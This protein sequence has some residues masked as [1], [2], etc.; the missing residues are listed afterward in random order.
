MQSVDGERSWWVQWGPRSF[1]GGGG[2]GHPSTLK[3]HLGVMQIGQH[4]LI[5]HMVKSPGLLLAHLLEYKH[6][7]K[8]C[9][10]PPQTE[11]GALPL[12]EM[13]AQGAPGHGFPEERLWICK[14]Q[15]VL[16]V[17]FQQAW[18]PVSRPWYSSGR[19]AVTVCGSI[20]LGIFC[21]CK[22]KLRQGAISRL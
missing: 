12:P 3:F 2:K 19:V 16:S 5:W 13:A 7:S 21:K 1:I 18:T 17:C 15:I 14:H 10:L 4:H 9:E 22:G 20:W 8:S 6:N 11:G